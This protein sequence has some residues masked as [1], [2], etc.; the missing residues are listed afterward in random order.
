MSQTHD[1]YFYTPLTLVIKEGSKTE[2]KG[3]N[4]LIW[5]LIFM[6]DVK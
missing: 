6:N 1:K 5:S 4:F 2:Y 3:V